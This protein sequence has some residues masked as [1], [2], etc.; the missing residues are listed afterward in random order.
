MT[1]C[2]IKAGFPF[3]CADAT[4]PPTTSNLLEL[5]IDTN[6]DDVSCNDYVGIDEH[7]V[8]EDDNDNLDHLISEALNNSNAVHID[9]DTDEDESVENENYSLITS[10]MA[11]DYVM[12]IKKFAMQTQQT[13]IL[14]DLYNLSNKIQSNMAKRSKTQTTINKYFTKKTY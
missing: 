2:F 3:E 14:D 12:A 1:N 8:T 9:S 4:S 6:F 5:L 10:R 7:T 13:D 11:L